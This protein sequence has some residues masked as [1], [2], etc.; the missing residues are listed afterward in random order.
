LVAVKS[1]VLVAWSNGFNFQGKTRST[2]ARLRPD[3]RSVVVDAGQ[4]GRNRDVESARSGSPLVAHG[5]LRDVGGG[6]V[7]CTGPA[8]IGDREI[9]IRSR[10]GPRGGIEAAVEGEL[11]GE[12]DWVKAMAAGSG[13]IEVSAR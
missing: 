13:E 6:A 10:T 11:V 12:G 9:R 2:P 7:M 8:M 5:D 4:L 1:P 3:A